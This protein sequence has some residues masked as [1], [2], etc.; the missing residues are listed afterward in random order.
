MH[1]LG[2]RVH[3]SIKLNSLYLEII[4]YGTMILTNV[5]IAIQ[6]RKW[7]KYMAV[8]RKPVWIIATLFSGLFPVILFNELEIIKNKENNERIT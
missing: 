7:L 2:L 3:N 1:N 4:T 6:F 8:D 5:V